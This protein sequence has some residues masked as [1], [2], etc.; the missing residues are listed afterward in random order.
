[1]PKNITIYSRPTCAPCNQ[2]KQ[3]LKMKGFSYTIKDID[4]NPDNAAEA[5]G[6][7]GA[8]IV[9]VTVVTKEDDTKEVISGY[10]LGRLVPLLA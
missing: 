8:S 9:P 3:F 5:Y 2:L 1:M 6:Y 10:N 7:S 4:S